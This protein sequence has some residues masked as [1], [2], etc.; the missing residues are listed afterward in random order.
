MHSSFILGQILVLATIEH[1]QQIRNNYQFSPPCTTPD[2]LP[3]HG[4]SG[5]E[6]WPHPT[7]NSRGALHGAAWSTRWME[8]AYPEYCEQH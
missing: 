7:R 8:L 1:L 5:V 2:G 6:G 4:Q 3:Q